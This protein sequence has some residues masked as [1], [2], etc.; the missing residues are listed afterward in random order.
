MYVIYQ[1]TV[2]AN[3]RIN[4]VNFVYMVFMSLLYRVLLYERS[5]YEMCEMYN[6]P[7]TYTVEEDRLAWNSEEM[8][9]EDRVILETEITLKTGPNITMK[10]HE[11]SRCNS[12]L[13]G[14]FTESEE[15]SK[16]RAIIKVLNDDSETEG[17]EESRTSPRTPRKVRFG[18]ESVKLR[19]PES[20]SSHQA[21]E[22]DNQSILT[23]TS[24]PN[25]SALSSKIPIRKHALQEKKKVALETGETSGINHTS[26]KAAE[27]PASLKPPILKHSRAEDVLSPVP[28]HNEIEVFHNLT[29][30][31]ER[32]RQ[33]S[34]TGENKEEPSELEKEREEPAA[35]AKTYDSFQVYKEVPLLKLPKESSVV[36]EE[37]TESNALK[38]HNG[39]PS[40]LQQSLSSLTSEDE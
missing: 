34:L 40:A 21:E 18:G 29:R 30:S 24:A 7:V 26:S 14:T 17:Y 2:Q 12:E 28:V 3:V 39:K 10:I 9:Q 32:S 20:D 33:S 6:C 11:E 36:I 19:T 25:L 8:V 22:E 15:D 16:R 4:N 13:S 1:R 37:I 31:P 23:I 5:Y 35:Q 38:V 27:K